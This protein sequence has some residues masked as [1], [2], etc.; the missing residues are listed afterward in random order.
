VVV[1]HQSGNGAK[2]IIEI[3]I[4]TQPSFEQEVAISFYI[5]L[6]IFGQNTGVPIFGELNHEFLG[7]LLIF[8][9]TDLGENGT[10]LIQKLLRIFRKLFDVLS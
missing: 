9:Y 10:Q 1:V 8:F 4:A 6:Y 3:R 5:I 7:S 2:I